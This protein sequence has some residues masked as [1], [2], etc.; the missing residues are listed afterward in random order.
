MIKKFISKMTLLLIVC[1]MLGLV[2]TACGNKNSENSNKAIVESR[3]EKNQAVIEPDVLPMFQTLMFHEISDEKVKGTTSVSKEKLEEVLKYLSENQYKFLTAQEAYDFL[4][5]KTLIPEKSIWLTF[6]DGLKSAYTAATPL[7]KKYGAKATGFVE[8]KQI[9]YTDRLTNDDLKAMVSSGIWDIQSHGYNGH[10]TPLKDEN[11]NRVNFYF[12]R[13]LIGDITE[14]EDDFK[15]RIEKDVSK[16]FDILEKE[17]GSKRCFF[18]YPLDGAASENDKVVKTIESCLDKI[19]I[20]GMGVNGSRRFPVD[21]SN[22]KHCY[23]RYGITDSSNIEDILSLR[24]SGKYICSDD[25]KCTYLLTNF[26][27]YM[28]SEYISWNNNGNIAVIDK[29]MRIK[30]NSIEIKNVD[31]KSQLKLKGKLSFAVKPEDAIWMASW[32]A[33]K[34]YELTEDWVVKKQ[35]KLQVIPAAIWFNGDI[36]YILDSRGS[37]YSWVGHEAELEYKPDYDVQ[38]VGG[39]VSGNTIYVGASSPK[40]IY[41]IDYINGTIIDSKSYD[42]RYIIVPEI[43]DKENEFIANDMSSNLLMRVKY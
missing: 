3:V 25:E 11:G 1:L 10:S 18:A 34:L 37:I 14:T 2:L 4:V 21:W 26:A 7:L 23:T 27:Q 15:R 39:C 22:P 20:L 40:K 30:N 41:K 28:N 9:G 6:D 43:A 32:D 42:S 33:K 38:C 35:Y 12:N 17:Y 24:N 19:N 16:S 5:K 36:L 29:D 8:V 13:L 31:K